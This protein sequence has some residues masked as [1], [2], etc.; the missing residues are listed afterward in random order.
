MAQKNAECQKMVSDAEAEKEK[1]LAEAREKVSSIRG[2]MKRE[3][4][5]VSN[6]MASLMQSVE[7]VVKACNETKVITDKAFK[8]IDVPKEKPAL[9]D[10]DAEEIPQIKVN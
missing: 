1:L 6:Y 10:E 2:S 5:N 8:G 3:C 7:G 9:P 4:E